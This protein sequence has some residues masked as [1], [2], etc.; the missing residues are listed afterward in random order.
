MTTLIQEYAQH[1]S[2][3]LLVNQALAAKINNLLLNY[4]QL[5]TSKY[6]PW[7]VRL[8]EIT[9]CVRAGWRKSSYL[10]VTIPYI[11]T[12]TT[13]PSQ[14]LLQQLGLEYEQ[15]MAA[16]SRSVFTVAI[17][18]PDHFL[19]GCK[20]K[21]SLTTNNFGHTMPAIYLKLK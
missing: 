15:I 10:L 13:W 3:P 14:L 19:H 11:C 1:N 9:D 18:A 6:H 7:N 5:L 17:S 8:A 4:A 2:V 16:A 21:L 20:L 12:N